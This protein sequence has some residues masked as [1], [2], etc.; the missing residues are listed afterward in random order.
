M[1]LTHLSIL[2]VSLLAAC[3]GAQASSPGSAEPATARPPIT[4]AQVEAAQLAWC[5]ALVG[6]GKLGAS[7]GDARGMASQVL[8]SAY[9]Y[10][11]GPVLFKPTLT[12]GAQTF[13][14]DKQGALAYFVGGD[15]AYP[16]DDGFAL[17]GWATCKPEIRNWV[18]DGDI[19]I[20]MGNVYLTD[21]KGGEVMVDKTWGYKRNA[22]GD[23]QIV[24][25]HSSLPFQPA[26]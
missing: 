5:E 1:K 22:A 21:G 10:D 18:T 12:H 19:A 6:I 9:A 24:L 4:Q 7:G 15:P 8:S 3:A 26:N 17:K 2:G 11:S 20:T 13:R 25:H 14:M 16:D 23:L